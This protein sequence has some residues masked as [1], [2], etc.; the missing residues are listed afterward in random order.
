MNAY[1]K[2][3]QIG[4]T[5]E[6]SEILAKLVVITLHP[7]R[8]D[9]L[10]QLLN[11]RGMLRKT[12][13]SGGQE[14]WA[15]TLQNLKGALVALGDTSGVQAYEM[16]F[17]HVTNPRQLN[18]DTTIPEYAI[19]LAAMES[20][21]AGLE[22]MPTQADFDAIIELGGGRPYKNVSV[23]DYNYQKGVAEAAVQ[24]DLIATEFANKKVNWK[25]RAKIAIDNYGTGLQSVGISDIRL[26]ADEMEA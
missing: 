22:N 12:D 19:P 11:F 24:A 9:Y 18:W 21:F 20:N 16:W 17:S 13:G 7:I 14:R 23:D 15:G 2:A 5:G 25:N 10:M 6:P 26:I 4:L 3:Q 1:E 8:L